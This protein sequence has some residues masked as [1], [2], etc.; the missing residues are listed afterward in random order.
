MAPKLR[1][2]IAIMES[3]GEKLPKVRSAF[4]EKSINMKIISFIARV[5]LEDQTKLF[6]LINNYLPVLT[7]ESTS[8]EM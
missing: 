4:Y 3:L 7:P 6:T 2:L 1:L 5:E 8:K